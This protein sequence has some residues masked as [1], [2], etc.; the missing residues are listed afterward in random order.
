MPTQPDS[1]VSSEISAPS[2]AP[3][4][5]P[6]I[7]VLRPKLPS[8]DEIAP[9]LR[10]IDQLR[11]YS[12]VGPLSLRLLTELARHLGCSEDRL[13][14][15][16]SATSGL[17]AA[18]LAL[19]L[20]ENALCLMPSWTF[21]ATPH[22]ALAAG[23]K[24]WFLDVQERTWSLSPPISKE[25]IPPNVRALIVVSP[26]GVP[27]DIR[28]WEKFQDETNIPVI[29]DAAAG[30]DTVRPSKLISVVS[31]HATKIFAAGEG[32]LVIAPTREMRD[33][34]RA[35]SNFGFDGTRIA[36]YRAINSKMSEY[37]AA[38]ALASL[39]DWPATRLRHLRIAAWYRQAFKGVPNVA[40]QPGY[41]EGWACG[42]TNVLL[43][44]DSA[45]S[46]SLYLAREGVETRKWWG[47]GCHVHPAFTACGCESL[48]VT[49]YLGLHTLGLPHFIDLK[50]SDVNHVARTLAHALQSR[51]SGKPL[52]QTRK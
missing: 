33:R 36:K 14:M 9:Y 28:A 17:T 38:V 49:D 13:I 2:S 31:L 30:F 44:S 1:A 7:P 45:E 16:A 32:G 25:S 5:R 51:T 48:P 6:S 52:N 27:I 50:K 18:L 22:A 10:S 40:L 12:N 39:R 3:D 37:H 24:P 15:A 42:N 43:E 41:G 23:L 29:I 19:N 21:A 34:I 11:I 26:F 35:C 20:P 47:N 8:A 4:T 46:I